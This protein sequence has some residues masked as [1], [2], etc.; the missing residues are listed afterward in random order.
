MRSGA[1]DFLTKPFDMDEL[2]AIVLRAIAERRRNAGDTDSS[3][4]VRSAPPFENVT[5]SGDGPAMRALREAVGLVARSSASVLIVGETG[6]GKELAARVIHAKSRRCSHPFV[7][8]NT[9]A[10][11]SELLE[12]ELFG[13]VRGAFTG[14]AQARKG[15]VSEAEGGTLFL[16]EIGDMPLPLQA[17]LLRVIQFR[18]VRSVGAERSH[19]V[20][21]RFI[22]ATHQDLPALVREGRFREDLYYRLNV[23]PVAVPSLRDRREDIPMLSG[24]FLAD[25][26]RRTPESPVRSISPEAMQVLAAAPWRGNVRQLESAI[27]RL[28]V[29]GQDEVITPKAFPGAGLGAAL[30]APETLA[31]DAAPWPGTI[32]E[33]WTLKR[34]TDA[35]T[36]W[37]LAGN[38]G[39]MKDAA[40]TLGVDLSTL[41]RWKRASQGRK[42]A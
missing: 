8:V 42:E 16:D 39:N 23:L 17:K 34:L 2:N 10:I 33:P 36:E 5:L 31:A 20:D 38:G 15:L 9:A 11:P 18:E 30:S 41:Y 37:V 24:I 19:P 25:A 32:R 14:A 21:V 12:S 4:R 22:A 26:K 35:Y 7:P 6:A 40:S 13:H 29:F 1:Y 28:V 3:R 27:E